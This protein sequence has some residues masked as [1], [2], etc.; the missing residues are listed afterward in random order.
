VRTRE[1]FPPAMDHKQ[2]TTGAHETHRVQ[3]LIEL[4]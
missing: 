4:S 1:V 3:T 2:L